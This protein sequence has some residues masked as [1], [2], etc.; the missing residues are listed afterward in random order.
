MNG[1]PPWRLLRAASDT[2]FNREAVLQAGFLR[3]VHVRQSARPRNRRAA[4]LPSSADKS[5][6]HI[7]RMHSD[8]NYPMVSSHLVTLQVRRLNREYAE[9]FGVADL[10]PRRKEPFTRDILVNVILGAP[11]GLDLGC[12][13]LDWTTRSGRSLRAL[14]ATLAQTGLR[15]GEV[16][17]D[18][19]GQPCSYRCLSRH[20]LRWLLR[21]CVYAS[22]PPS[23]AL[24]HP[25]PGDYAIL[26]PPPSKSDPFDVVWG[27]NPIWLPYQPNEPLCAFAALAQINMR[28]RPVC[29]LLFLVGS[30]Y[31]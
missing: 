23:F 31:A 15:K 13:V 2:D 19:A 14:T 4:A 16:C 27:G 21:G 7:R 8:R 17:V 18:R 12:V 1:T 6:R 5:L 3:F 22:S 30:F 11:A 24:L 28:P 26:I 25:N 10:V 29:C 9:R 20:G